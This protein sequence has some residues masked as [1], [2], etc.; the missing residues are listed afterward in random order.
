MTVSLNG[1]NRIVVESLK[2]QNF[3]PRLSQTKE[4]DP[5]FSQKVIEYSTVLIYQQ[6]CSI[7]LLRC[8][9]F[10]FLLMFYHALHILGF[11]MSRMYL[12]YNVVHVLSQFAI[13]VHVSLFPVIV[14]CKSCQ[15]FSGPF[16]NLYP[17]C[18]KV[19]SVYTVPS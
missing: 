5:T 13:L 15:C 2:G 4:W 16:T 7:W 10:S 14:S 18:H 3:S 12:Q 19:W 9:W 8:T 11:G 1:P 17:S 6:R